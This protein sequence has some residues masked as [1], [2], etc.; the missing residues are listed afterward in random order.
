MSKIAIAA[1]L[2][3]TSLGFASSAYASGKVCTDCTISAGGA[4]SCKQC[5]EK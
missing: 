2:M 5:S 1:A 4:M 3:A